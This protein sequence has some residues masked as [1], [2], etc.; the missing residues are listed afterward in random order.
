MILSLLFLLKHFSLIN[1]NMNKWLHRAE[2]LESTLP[3]VSQW[4][5]FLVKD[6]RTW[7]SS[8]VQGLRLDL[9]ARKSNK[10]PQ[11]IWN[12][13]ILPVLNLHFRCVT[14]KNS[15]SLFF[16]LSVP[17][18]SAQRHRRK[19]LGSKAVISLPTVCIWF[20]QQWV[21]QTQGLTA[22]FKHQKNFVK[23]YIY[24]SIFNLYNI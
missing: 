7:K 17:I 10:G 6:L 18:R 4:V 16:P 23:T 14:V 3:W 2:V 21:H 15:K 24:I 11:N 20:C 19:V 9:N 22:T 12:L 13:Q 8:S 1:I 5:G